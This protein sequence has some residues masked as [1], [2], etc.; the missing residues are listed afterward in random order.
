MLAS[1]KEGIA[2]QGRRNDDGNRCTQ[3]YWGGEA[4]PMNGVLDD[5]TPGGC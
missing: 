2:A 1:A 4:L 3:A 5:P